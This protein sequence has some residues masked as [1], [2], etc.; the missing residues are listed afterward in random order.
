MTRHQR[1]KRA[2][3]RKTAKVVARNLRTPLAFE[4]SGGQ[5]SGVYRG[6]HAPR[7]YGTGVTPMTHKVTRVYGSPR[8]HLLFSMARDAVGSWNDNSKR[9]PLRK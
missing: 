9:P 5:V 7:A 3:A 6:L 8:A 2:L 4:R 1:R